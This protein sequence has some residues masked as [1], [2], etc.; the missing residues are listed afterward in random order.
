MYI[1]MKTRDF[2]RLWVALLVSERVLVIPKILRHHLRLKLH[3]L[4]IL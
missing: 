1:S 2:L 4:R 3:M